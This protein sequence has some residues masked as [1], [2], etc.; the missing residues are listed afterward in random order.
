MSMLPELAGRLEDLDFLDSFAKP[1][2]KLT[3]RAVRPRPVRNFLSGTY[4]GHPLHPPLT[5]LPIGAWAMSGL[6]DTLGGGEGAASASDLLIA[7]GIITA[8][9]TALAGLNDWSDTYGG[10]TRVGLVHAAA[11]TTASILY[12]SSL[13]ARRAGRRRLGRALGK[14]GLAAVLLGGYL[15][16]HLTF[17]KGVNVNH[18]AFEHGPRNW[19]PVLNDVELVEGAQRRVFAGDVPVVVCREAGQIYALAATCTHAGGPLD[20][21]KVSDGCIVCPWHG[22]T[23]RLSDGRIGRGPASAAQPSYAT[24]VRDGQIEVRASR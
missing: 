12:T 5:D 13:A 9:P 4:L 17:A 15:G 3:S 14:T 10:A 20:E 1:L 18:T 6:M 19:T 16:G 11:N 23:F 8:V 7:A 21:G 2:A 24:R 22:S